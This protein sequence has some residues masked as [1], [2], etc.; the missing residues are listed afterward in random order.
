MLLFSD[1]RKSLFG[2]WGLGLGP[3]IRVR[4]IHRD[5]RYIDIFIFNDNEI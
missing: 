3:K 1:F 2:F 4:L 5:L